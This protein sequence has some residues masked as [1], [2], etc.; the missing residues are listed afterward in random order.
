MFHMKRMYKNSSAIVRS[1]LSR[2]VNR[3]FRFETNQHVTFVNIRIGVQK[4]E[5]VVFLQHET[6][7][8]RIIWWS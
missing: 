2:I 3:E 8:S 5:I 4:L 6:R 7:S 1:I